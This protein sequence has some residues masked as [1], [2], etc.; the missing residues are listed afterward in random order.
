[1]YISSIQY[2]TQ[3][4]ASHSV[5]STRSTARV[6]GAPC[7]LRGRGRLRPSSVA[8]LRP[9]LHLCSRG[10]NSSGVAYAALAP[11]RSHPHI[12]HADCLRQPLQGYG[13][14]TYPPSSVARAR[15]PRP[16]SPSQVKSSQ[17][18]P[19]QAE[20]SQVKSS[21]ILSKPLQCSPPPPPSPV[22][23]EPLLQRLLTGDQVLLDVSY[24]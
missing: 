8:V 24:L 21:Q 15:R 2:V 13:L 7:G 18:K 20:S 23:L 9:A 12:W 5:G 4:V 22:P 16:G 3:V 10:S 6:C 11:R 14:R 19:S 1:V 17:V